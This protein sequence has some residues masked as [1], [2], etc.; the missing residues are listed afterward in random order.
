[1]HMIITHFILTY[2]IPLLA[3]IHPPRQCPSEK[4][5]RVR[6]FTEHLIL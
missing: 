3:K 1:M 4:K 5:T 6:Q 2:V